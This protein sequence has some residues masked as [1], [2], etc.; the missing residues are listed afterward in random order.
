MAVTAVTRLPSRRSK[1]V[2]DAAGVGALRVTKIENDENSF[3]V[4]LLG[5]T[6]SMK[7]AFESKAAQL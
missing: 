7:G 4:V 5:A 1:T 2:R 6:P 3:A